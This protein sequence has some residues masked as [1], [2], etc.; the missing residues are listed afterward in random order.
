MQHFERAPL[1][2]PREW[3]ERW[4]NFHPSEF[5]CRCCGEVAVSDRL[6]DLLQRLRTTMGAPLIV[7]SGF[8][9]PSHNK[10]VGGAPASQHMRGTAADVVTAGHDVPH[11]LKLAEDFG[12]GGLG[13]YPR[14][15]F[16]HI[17]VRPKNGGHVARWD[18]GKFPR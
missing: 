1:H 10:A 18:Q 7:T 12:A 2:R 8:R 17:D 15:G 13:E 3:V 4:P 6:L 5:A 16:V 14:Q 11:M 9:C